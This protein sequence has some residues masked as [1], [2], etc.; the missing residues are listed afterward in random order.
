MNKIIIIN[1][2]VVKKEGD[3]VYLVS[4]IEDSILKTGKDYFFSV[5][6]EFGEYLTHEVADAFVS[7]MLMPAIMTGQDIIVKAPISEVFYY[8]LENSLIYAICK[9]F[10]KPL[11]KIAPES[12]VSPKFTSKAVS[13]GFSGGVDSFATVIQHTSNE[14]PDSLKLTHLTLMNVGSYGDTEAAFMKFEKDAIRSKEYADKLKLPLVLINSNIASAYSRKECKLL[15]GFASRSIISLNSGLLALQKLYKYYFISSSRT[16]DKV[17]LYTFNQAYYEYLI[18][19][20]LSTTNTRSI[21]ANGSLDRIE[22]IKYIVDSEDAHERLYV[23]AAEIYNEKQTR[24]YSKDGFPNCSECDK[25]TRTL[26]VLDV[27]NKLHLF[28]KRF[29]LDKTE[30]LKPDIIESIYSRRKSD[31]W[32]KSIYKFMQEN[33]YSIPA[34]VKIK[35]NAMRLLEKPFQFILNR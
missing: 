5:Q 4:K 25:C 19:S 14:C 20:F 24:E 31:Y 15:H 21:I 8:N 16:I 7:A 11:I 34:Q 17:K 12:L 33:N 32:F 9:T 3:T 2:P 23:C 27:M 29:N 22:K 1:K 6:E 13:T 26:V 28:K 18:A 35:Y 10:N 30:Y